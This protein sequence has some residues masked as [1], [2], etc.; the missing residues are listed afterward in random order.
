VIYLCY[1]D[2][3]DVGPD[4]EGP[5]RE[6]HVLRPGLVFVDSEQHRSAVYHALKDHLPAGT[7]L[8]VTELHEVPKHKGMAPGSLAWARARL[9]SG[10]GGRASDGSRDR[11]PAEVRAVAG[12]REHPLERDP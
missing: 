1:L 10:D 8:L 7:P 9:G 6:V 3:H 4:V 12:Q 5:W 2:G 11:G